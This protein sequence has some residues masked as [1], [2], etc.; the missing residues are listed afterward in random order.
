MDSKY[1][2]I[3]IY[4]HPCSGLEYISELM[5]LKY[6]NKQSIMGY[7]SGDGIIINPLI[8]YIYVTRKFID[9]VKTFYENRDK[10]G[11]TKDISFEDFFS[12]RYSYMCN[13]KTNNDLKN[14]KMSPRGYWEYH[15]N[16]WIKVSNKNDNVITISYDR[17]LKNNK[18]YMET[19]N[20]YLN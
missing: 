13:S 18:S 16:T 20:K 4:G 7:R 3:H 11:I 9:V 8:L 2:Q 15:I 5:Q 10:F 6:S 17:V 1:N 19:I 12:E 14:I